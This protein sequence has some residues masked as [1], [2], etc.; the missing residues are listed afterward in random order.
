MQTVYSWGIHSRFWLIRI[1][2]LSCNPDIMFMSFWLAL[3][4][5]ARIVVAEGGGV[6]FLSYKLGFHK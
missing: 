1:T 4:A 6:A 2:N 5:V 3:P